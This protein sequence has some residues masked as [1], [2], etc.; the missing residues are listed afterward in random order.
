MPRKKYMRMLITIPDETYN[1]FTQTVPA[2]QRSKYIVRLLNK[3]LATS[4]KSPKT[5]WSDLHKN[6]KG[7]Y[8]HEDPVEIA[9]NAWKDV[10]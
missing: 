2:G 7:D 6:L 8:S 9:H 1:N 5:F 3:K 10:D 4:K